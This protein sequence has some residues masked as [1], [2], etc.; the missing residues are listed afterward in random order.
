MLPSSDNFPTQHQQKANYE[1]TPLGSCGPA[2]PLQVE[3]IGRRQTVHTSNYAKPGNDEPRILF[4]HEV[5]FYWWI[6]RQS[7]DKLQFRLL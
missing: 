5:G 6:S 4:L 1:R 7:K 3:W 2:K